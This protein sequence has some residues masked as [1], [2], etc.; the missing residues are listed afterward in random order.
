MKILAAI[1]AA[2]LL[3]AASALADGTVRVRVVDAATQHPVSGVVVTVDT[4]AGVEYQ[5][6]TDKY[7]IAH[8]LTVPDGRAAALVRD[9]PYLSLCQNLFT[10]SSTQWREMTLEVTRERS[11][12]RPRACTISNLVN[13]GEGADVYNVF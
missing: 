9:E 2:M 6:T 10:V 3:T 5:E 12:V 4:L 11:G 1:A 7:G 13:P 8:F